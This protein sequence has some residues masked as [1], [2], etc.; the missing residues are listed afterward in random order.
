MQSMGV[1]VL[2]QQRIATQAALLVKT[3][4][5]YDEWALWGSAVR[6]TK[7]VRRCAYAVPDERLPGLLKT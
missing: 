4:V 7:C 2:Q 3:E 6:T 5:E 1:L